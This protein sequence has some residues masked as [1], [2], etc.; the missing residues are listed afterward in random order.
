MGL[1]GGLM[2]FAT[3]VL[4]ALFA[5]LLIAGFRARCAALEL[6][7][8]WGLLAMLQTTTGLLDFSLY[9]RSG[10]S[11]LEATVWA[12]GVVCAVVTVRGQRWRGF[13][14]SVGVALVATVILAF[15]SPPAHRFIM[16][17]A[18]DE[19]VN[20]LRELSHARLQ[21]DGISEPLCFEHTRPGP[22]MTRAAQDRRLIAMTR[23]YTLFP[24]DQGDLPGTVM[25][26]AAHII[27]A[28]VGKD[29][30]MPSPSGPILCLLDGELDLGDMGLLSRISPE[31]TSA[32]AGYQPL[33]HAP[34][35]RI[36]AFLASLPRNSWS[37]TTEM[38][39]PKLKLV[40][41]KPID[42]P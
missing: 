11:L 8:G 19:L 31:L 38:R 10:W 15:Y 24:G 2:T 32:L 23:C 12:G 7:G 13:R 5:G 41:A 22:L 16:S 36:E 25:D 4:A 29:T 9:Q 35:R 6:L 3:L 40:L 34:N 1:G 30:P 37:V 27:R 17:G 20:A 39:G 26:P 18:E 28:L 14:T 33:L 42:T 21:A